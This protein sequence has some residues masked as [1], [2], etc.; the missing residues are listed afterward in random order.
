MPPICSTA[1]STPAW[2]RRSVDLNAIS[3]ARCATPTA[4]C[5]ANDWREPAST[6]MP[7]EVIGMYVSCVTTRSPLGSVVMCVRGCGG[8]DAGSSASD[9]SGSGTPG[10]GGRISV[11]GI[12]LARQASLD[13]GSAR[14]L[15]PRD[16]IVRLALLIAERRLQA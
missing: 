12:E 6:T 15:R 3:S 1:A 8:R 4:P 11:S 16:L 14:L 9:A 5:V 7:S 13:H 10:K 2:S